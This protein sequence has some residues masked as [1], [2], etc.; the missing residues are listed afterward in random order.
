MR[1]S[2]LPTGGT[3]LFQEIK[4]VSAQAQQNGVKLIKLSIG[5]PSGPALFS[6]RRAAAQAV[7]SEEEYPCTNIR[8]TRPPGFLTL[9]E[10]L[11]LAI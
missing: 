9:P 11:W 10:G 5:Q 2:K 3:N 6:A 8:T 1:E 7:M 4:A